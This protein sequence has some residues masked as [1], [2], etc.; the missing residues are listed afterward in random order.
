M[1]IYSIL[2]SRWESEPSFTY[3]VYNYV[4]YCLLP[5]SLQAGGFHVIVYLLLYKHVKK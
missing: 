4:S 1:F 2:T 5:L 3:L